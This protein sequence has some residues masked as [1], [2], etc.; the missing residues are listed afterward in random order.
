MHSFTRKAL[1]LIICVGSAVVSVAVGL[2][3]WESHRDYRATVG[4]EERLIDEVAALEEE[5]EMKSAYMAALLENPE[6]LER[7]VRERLNL[8]RPGEVIFRYHDE[9]EIY[10]Y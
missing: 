5:V 8:A 2:G 1:S 3:L 6:F 9:S 10:G 7:T 4:R